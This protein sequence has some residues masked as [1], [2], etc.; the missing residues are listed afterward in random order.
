MTV[1]LGM[2]P[3]SPLCGLAVVVGCWRGHYATA[4]WQFI[5]CWSLWPLVLAA[6]GTLSD[7]SALAITGTPLCI[8]AAAGLDEAILWRRTIRLCCGK[9][10]GGV[11]QSQRSPT[12]RD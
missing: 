4:F 10:Q 7:R 6:A 1:A 11:G 2:L 9:Q 3:W 5:A 8:L 12:Q